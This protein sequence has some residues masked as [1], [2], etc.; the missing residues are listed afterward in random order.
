MITGEM[1]T[2]QCEEY[3]ARIYVSDSS[4]YAKPKPRPKGAV[5]T[6]K[7]PPAQEPT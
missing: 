2:L 6:P 3:I 5:L 4:I 1:E 7:D